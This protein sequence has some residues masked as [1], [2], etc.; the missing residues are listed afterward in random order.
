MNKSL[1]IIFIT[2][3]IQGALF[4]QT[5]T[6]KGKITDS[7]T[8]ETIPGVNILSDQGNGSISDLNGTYEIKVK[9]GKVKLKFSYVGYNGLDKNFNLD[10]NQE[11]IFNCQMLEKTSYLDVFVVSG[12]A[13]QNKISE[14][15]V[16]ID[17]I[18][19]DAIKNNNIRSIDEALQKMP[20]IRIVDGQVSIRSGSGYSYGTGSRVQ[21]IVDGNSYLSPDLN[22][23]RW[24]FVPVDNIEQVEVIKGA[25]SVLYGSSS[26]NG[27]VNII[28]S[29][30]KSEPETRFMMYQGLYMNPRRDTLNW[31]K[32]KYSGA[33]VPNFNGLSATH[34]R[35]IGNFDI[36]VG[37]RYSNVQSYLYDNY[38]TKWGIDFKT[39]YRAPRIKGLTFGINGNYMMEYAER[40][41]FFKNSQE[42]GYLP[43]PGATSNDVYRSISLVP[44]L[45][46]FTK[47]G[48]RHKLTGMYYSLTDVETDG[49]KPA[50]ILTIDYQYQHHFGKNKS[51][52]LTSGLNGSY[53]WMNNKDLYEGVKPKTVF[54]SVYTQLEKKFDRLTFLAGL[55]F[56]A[57]M[58]TGFKDIDTSIFGPIDYEFILEKTN[59]IFR[60][61]FNYRITSKTFLRGSFGQAYRF[62]SIAERFIHVGISSIDIL[63]NLE[64]K[65]EKGIN[66]ELGLKQEIKIKNYNVAVDLSLFWMEYEN[67]I[68]YVLG[69][70]NE[71]GK[72]ELTTGFKPFNVK[73]ARIAGLEFM[74]QGQGKIGPI[75]ANFSGGYTF[76]YP[77]DLDADTSQ[78]NLGVYIQNLFGSLNGV[79]S[80]KMA[81]LLKYRNR[82]I[83]KFDLDLHYKRLAV[84]ITMDWNLNF[85]K[86]DGYFAVINTVSP[87]IND[88]L[89]DYPGGSSIWD[90]RISY[91]VTKTSRLSII[92][93]NLFNAEFSERPGLIG[94]PRSII[95]QL[96][97][98]F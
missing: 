85:E 90:A 7:K 58:L 79:D 76:T 59:P 98:M 31:W 74:L 62:P 27:V 71:P 65:P 66:F 70:Y 69:S 63:P 51:I 95:A 9:A 55:R 61:G 17:V 42:G 80:T 86:I 16:S 25:A 60:A 26:M 13:H 75:S 14:E 28:T 89:N 5:S 33:F 78:K 40:F 72:T 6:I 87:G 10:A 44:H 36:V 34:S 50:E 24:K 67:F 32:D 38:A 53:S 82:H 22:E 96:Q 56:E 43:L 91:D 19:P 30:P 83:F 81:G 29:W 39:R 37:A 20:G 41:V 35:K 93:K 12:S 77:V 88:Y 52:I 15:I 84:G 8:G 45:N 48:N 49:N 23:V 18:K 57:Y 92:S 73:N 4:S 97:V 54:A 64:L 2:L 94:P 1:L 68:N 3:F 21:V 11:R 46:Y 47:Q